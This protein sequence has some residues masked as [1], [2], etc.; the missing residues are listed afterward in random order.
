MLSHV[1]YVYVAQR[2]AQY[3]ETAQKVG[4]Y[5]VVVGELKGKISRMKDKRRERECQYQKDFEDLQTAANLI[6]VKEEQFKQQVNKINADRHDLEKRLLI[7]EA[8]EAQKSEEL[9]SLVKEYNE[10]K[11]YVSTHMVA[12][13]EMDSLEERMRKETIPLSEFHGLVE[14]LNTL[15]SQCRL[16]LVSK[17][18]YESIQRDRD[19]LSRT[20]KMYTDKMDLLE[21]EKKYVNDRLVECHAREESLKGEISMLNAA[22]AKVTDENNT[23]KIEIDSLKSITAD[24][25][26][27]CVWSSLFSFL[28]ITLR[29]IRNIHLSRNSMYFQVTCTCHRIS[30]C[31]HVLYT[32]RGASSEP[33][34]TGVRRNKNKY[35]YGSVFS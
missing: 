35:A 17:E 14:K 26:Y 4:E 19:E 2:L 3:A 8:S 33:S 1:L 7:I 9:I 22:I 23:M 21:R 15:R 12:I 5:E 11:Q 34:Q 31:A 13:E 16:N 32:H 24:G 28:V 10:F 18:E 30:V 6:Q 29:I 20:N 27:V 25:T